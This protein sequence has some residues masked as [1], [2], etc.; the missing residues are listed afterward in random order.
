MGPHSPHPALAKVGP[1][2]CKGWR[3]MLG[4][5]SLPRTSAQLMQKIKYS[6]PEL[7]YWAIESNGFS[8]SCICLGVMSEQRA[9]S[10]YLSELDRAVTT[11]R[12]GPT[13]AAGSL[14]LLLHMEHR[15]HHL[16]PW[17][18]VTGSLQNHKSTFRQCQV[19]Q[20]LPVCT[21]CWVSPNRHCFTEIIMVVLDLWA[22]KEGLIKKVNGSKAWSKCLE[23]DLF[24]PLSNTP[25]VSI[26]YFSSL[27]Q[28]N[29][30]HHKTYIFR[31]YTTF[32]HK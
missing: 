4:F 2:C 3:L 11:T 15:Q 21:L 5:N 27:G 12:K 20:S 26:Q 13:M 30:N 6:Y 8:V 9:G 28:C 14:F 29:W 10:G 31:L 17:W 7:L 23:T 16:R 19:L 22:L 18:G 1:C 32:P 25:P 24:L